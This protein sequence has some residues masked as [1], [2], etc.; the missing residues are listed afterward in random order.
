VKLQVQEFAQLS[1]CFSSGS[2][3]TTGWSSVNLP[4]RPA[5]GTVVTV[6]VSQQMAPDSA[7]KFEVSLHV[8]STALGL[9]LYRLHAWVLYD[10]QV[11]LN[12]GYVV[13]S[14]PQEPQDGGYYWSR[15]LEANP[16][17]LKPFTANVKMLSQC[18]IKNSDVLH[19]IVSLSGARS[20]QMADLPAL[21]AYRY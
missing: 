21:L 11:P 5:P 19:T 3:A 20:A 4:A 1:E 7:D 14:L 17:I 18:L 13:V 10:Q 12:A 15:S 2:L 16:N 8:P 9:H 6:P